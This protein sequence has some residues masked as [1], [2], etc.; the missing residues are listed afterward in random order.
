ML[1]TCQSNEDRLLFAILN[2]NIII[3]KKAPEKRTFY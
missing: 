1:Q 2:L 3:Q